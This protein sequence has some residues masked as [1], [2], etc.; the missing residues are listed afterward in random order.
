[1]L[2]YCLKSRKSRRS[3][4]LRIVKTYKGKLMI[5]SKLAACDNNKSRFT[6]N[7]KRVSYQV[8]LD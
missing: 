5:L 7:K 3:E 4:N 1:M 6:K 2:S 8:T